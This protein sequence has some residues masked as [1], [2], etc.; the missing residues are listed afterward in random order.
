MRPTIAIYNVELDET[1]IREMTDEEFATYEAIAKA[2]EAEQK[3]LAKEQTARD[4]A[5]AAAVA[6]LEALGLTEDDLKALL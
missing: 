2:H 3:A 6:K 1:V 5:R 4:K